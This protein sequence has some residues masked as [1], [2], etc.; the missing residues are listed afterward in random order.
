MNIANVKTKDLVDSGLYSTEAEAVQEAIRYLFQSRPELRIKFA[1]R[2]YESDEALSLAK[3]SSLAGVSIE[4]MK[5]IL[6]RQ[7]VPLRLGASTVEEAL[8]E[9]ENARAWLRK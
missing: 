1:V 3:A 7:N 8:E 4:R 2:Q 6:F 5:E 9:V